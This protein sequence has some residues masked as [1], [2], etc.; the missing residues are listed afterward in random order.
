ML[1][2][3]LLSLVAVILVAMAIAMLAGS[4]LLP[5]PHLA[6]SSVQGGAAVVQRFYAAVNETIATGDSTDLQRVVAPHFVEENPLPG[7]EPG[8][9][10]LE[11]YLITLHGSVPGLR[12]VAEVLVVSADQ[13]VTQVDVREDQTSAALPAAL[14][15]RPA[16]WSAVE[17]FRVAGGAIVGRWGNSDGLALARPLAVANHE[18]PVPTPRVVSLARV[19]M[20]PGTRW[21]APLAGPRLFFVDE[22]SLDVQAARGATT[23]DTPGAGTD[24]AITEEVPERVML[25][26]GRAWMA[27]AGAPIGMTNV[28]AAVAQLLVVT[29][30]EPTIPNGVVPEAVNLPPGITV[31]ILAGDLATRLGSGAVTIVL[32]QISLA[33]DADLSLSSAEGPILVAV[34]TA[35]LEAAVW[36]T[37]WV[38]DSRD[39]MS[40]ASHAALLTAE[41]GMLLEPGGV[42]TLHNDDERSA[43]ALVVAIQTDM[44]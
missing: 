25:A 31:Q 11:N 8:R 4:M 20:A 38:R 10:G 17:I 32:E 43:Q 40:V 23:K 15:G 35:Q 19:T 39:G 9:A 21:D 14:G 27:P 41:N 34:E 5:V 30:S 36:G 3:L 44:R 1:R 13:V 26:A 2:L 33:P 16:V 42:V 28:G 29:F 6:N 22:G 18:L 37:A 7:V 24:V 12:L